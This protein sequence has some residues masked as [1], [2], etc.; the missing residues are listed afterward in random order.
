MNLT[1]TPSA[2]GVSL[3]PFP[4]EDSLREYQ[5]HNVL[6]STTRVAG[7]ESARYGAALRIVQR[8]GVISFCAGL[9][10]RWV[11]PREESAYI[12]TPAR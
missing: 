8:L 7:V 9:H 12:S 10:L 1:P 4:I 2:D 3:P 11:N 6:Q 5:M